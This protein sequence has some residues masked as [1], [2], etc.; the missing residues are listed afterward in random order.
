MTVS[1]ARRDA[2]MRYTMRPKRK[3]EVL[4]WMLR[5]L[6]RSG[7]YPVTIW[8]TH[9]DSDTVSRD[10]QVRRNN[11]WAKRI[12]MACGERETCFSYAMQNGEPTGIWGATSP[13][14]RT[15]IRNI[16]RQRRISA[17]G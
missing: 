10:P 17:S 3:F 2:T 5:G 14:E 4:E 12:C 15:R 6:C 8:D 13:R 11:E 9:P 7:R 1:Q 16:A